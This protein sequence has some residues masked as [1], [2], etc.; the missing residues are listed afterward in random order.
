MLSYDVFYKL[1]SLKQYKIKKS[2]VHNQW[3]FTS[4]L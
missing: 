3:L 2:I 1:W 4:A